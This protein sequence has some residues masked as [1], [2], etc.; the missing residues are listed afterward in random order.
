[1]VKKITQEQA[2]EYVKAYVK[3]LKD[4]GLPITKAYLYGSYARNEARDWSDIDIAIITPKFESRFEA[5][6]YLWDRL[7]R[8]E[9]LQGL[10]PIGIHPDNFVDESPIAYWIKREGIEVEV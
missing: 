10:E 8:D 2:I 5:H 6:N 3:R 4:E 1:M 9:T 7:R